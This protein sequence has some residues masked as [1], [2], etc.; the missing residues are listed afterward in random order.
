MTPG[1]AKQFE[2]NEALERAMELFWQNGYEATSLT[3]LLEGMGIGRQSLYNTFG[4]K[5]QLFIAALRHYFQGQMA[6]GAEALAAPLPPLD[7]IRRLFETFAHRSEQNG[8]CGCFL[9]NTLAEFGAKDDEVGEIVKEFYGR[10]QGHIADTLREAQEQGDLAPHLDPD[11]TARTLM[12]QSQGMA[13][14]SKIFTVEELLQSS[15]DN[16]FSLLTPANPPS[17]DP[18]RDAPDS[19]QSE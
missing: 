13:L 1:P 19:S 7:R 17:S 2:Q 9:G 12:A 3:Q 14:M 10:A 15:L 11:A 18:R 8:A 4:D 5:R 16:I 6:L